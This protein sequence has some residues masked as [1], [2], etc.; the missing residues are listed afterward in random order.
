MHDSRFARGAE[1]RG[2]WSCFCFRSSLANLWLIS[3]TLRWCLKKVCGLGH[4][5]FWRHHTCFRKVCWIHGLH[6]TFFSAQAFIALN[7]PE[8]KARNYNTLA[9]PFTEREERV[10]GPNSGRKWKWCLQ[11][12]V[13]GWVWTV[14]GLNP[15]TCRIAETLSIDE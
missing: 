9:K 8:Q 12:H 2:V 11:K 6:F 3:Y 7:A 13:T 4:R 5:T 14:R 10:V 15:I 1:R